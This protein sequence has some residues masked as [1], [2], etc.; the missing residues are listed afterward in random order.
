MPS[1]YLNLQYLKASSFILQLHA[2]TDTRTD[3]HTHSIDSTYLELYNEISSFSFLWIFFSLF[4]PEVIVFPLNNSSSHCSFRSS[5]NAYLN[6][7]VKV[8]CPP[9]EPGHNAFLRCISPLGLTFTF[10]SSTH[11]IYW[12]NVKWT[13]EIIN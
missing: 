9:A 12:R 2:Q 4:W 10:I 8:R 3:T 6:K 13:A 1:P 7:E 11:H 5:T